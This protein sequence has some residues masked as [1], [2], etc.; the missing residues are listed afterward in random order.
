VAS[1]IGG[2]IALWH[3]PSTLFMSIALGFASGTLLGTISFE[4]IPQAVELS[5]ATFSGSM[6]YLCEML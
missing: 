1:P 4:V 2:L 3:K 5:S 6:C